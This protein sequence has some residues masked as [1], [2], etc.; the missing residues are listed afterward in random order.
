M[1]VSS[2]R[3][4]IGSCR[5]ELVADKAFVYSLRTFGVSASR[6]LY[7]HLVNMHE[8]T[9]ATQCTRGESALEVESIAGNNSRIP[10]SARG[11]RT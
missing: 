8:E 11:S 7:S 4:S 2:E 5:A 3:H 1:S 10:R 9:A 6:N